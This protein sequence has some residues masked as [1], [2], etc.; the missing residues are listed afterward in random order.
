MHNISGRYVRLIGQ[1]IT[2]LWSLNALVQPGIGTIVKIKHRQARITLRL[3]Q[4][5]L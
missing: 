3:R 1:A 4:G 2:Y 5:V